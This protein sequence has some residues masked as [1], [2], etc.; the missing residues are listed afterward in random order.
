MPRHSDMCSQAYAQLPHKHDCLLSNSVR[1]WDT[2]HMTPPKHALLTMLNLSRNP[3]KHNTPGPNH[4]KLTSTAAKHMHLQKARPQKA[5][6]APQLPQQ[7]QHNPRSCNTYTTIHSTQTQQEYIS[8]VHW[9][10]SSAAD[11]AAPI[12]SRAPQACGPVLTT[13]TTPL[14]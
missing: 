11:P 10:L 8:K 14:G 12:Y 5:A 7:R 1:E 6:S 2:M 13:H 4:L 9:E 3:C